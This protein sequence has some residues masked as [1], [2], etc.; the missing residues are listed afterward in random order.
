MAETCQNDSRL[1]NSKLN[2]DILKGNAQKKQFIFLQIARKY[3]KETVHLTAHSITKDKEILA[4][5][6]NPVIY[7]LFSSATKFHL[8][9]GFLSEK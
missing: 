3:T 1:V 9:F 5:I 4:N 6:S 8:K 7:L 2:E